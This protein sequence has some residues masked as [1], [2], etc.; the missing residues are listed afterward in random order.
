MTR[1]K[2]FPKK[3]TKHPASRKATAVKMALVN[4][5]NSSLTISQNAQEWEI[6]IVTPLSATV[7]ICPRRGTTADVA[8][9]PMK[10][11]RNG[12]WQAQPSVQQVRASE[13][14]RRV[15]SNGDEPP[16]VAAPD[17]KTAEMAMGND[18]DWS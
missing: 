9:L 11:V 4:V 18:E 10:E 3:S 1:P 13:R 15:V 6:S 2:K 17:P 5:E 12:F 8:K 7:I 14:E 16:G